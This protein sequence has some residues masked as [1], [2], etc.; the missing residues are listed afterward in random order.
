M[1]HDVEVGDHFWIGS[2]AIILPNVSIGSNS[3][4][5]AGAAVTESIAPH[6]L[7]GGV[8]ARLIRVV[9]EI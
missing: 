9:N 3:I 1:I 7:V 5:A 8:R 2:N 4:I 6:S